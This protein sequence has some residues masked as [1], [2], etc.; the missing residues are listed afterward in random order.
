MGVTN[1]V[2]DARSTSEIEFEIGIALRA[3]RLK[4]NMDQ[5][6]LALQAGIGLASLQRLEQGHGSTLSTL[7][8]VTRA[9]GLLG[10][11]QHLGSTNDFDPFALLKKKP[12]RQRAST[13]RKVPK[14]KD[15]NTA[16]TLRKK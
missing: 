9:L 10:W 14:S 16:L 8:R 7:I 11:M 3:A 15:R 4:G 6:T 12:E 1:G 13:S 5:K 2:S